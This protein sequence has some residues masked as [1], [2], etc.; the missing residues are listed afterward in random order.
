MELSAYRKTFE[1]ISECTSYRCCSLCR[2]CLLTWIP[3]ELQPG[4][5]EI[6]AKTRYGPVAVRRRVFLALTIQGPGVFEVNDYIIDGDGMSR[7]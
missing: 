6:V 5:G 3:R 7:N 1:T 2:F 4:L